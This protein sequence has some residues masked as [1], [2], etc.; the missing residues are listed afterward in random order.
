MTY[1]PHSEYAPQYGEEMLT[2]VV[3][4]K[5]IRNGMA[6]VESNPQSACGGCASSV[7][8]G[9]KSLSSYMAKPLPPLV[10]HNDFDG[11]IGDQIE[12]GIPQSSLMKGAI[13][14]YLLPLACML[15]GAILG[16]EI[17]KENSFQLM[18]GIAGFVFGAMYARVFMRSE[19]FTR[20]LKPV[21]IKK[22]QSLFL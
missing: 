4:I 18:G 11:N 9:T 2:T 8:C 21:F 12:I 3:R 15:A 22:T 13:L 5:A 7:G 20:S 17:A 6:I 16:G 14:V 10:M 19:R 1:S